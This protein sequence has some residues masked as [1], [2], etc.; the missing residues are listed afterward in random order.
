[1]NVKGK[2]VL[3]LCLKRQFW[4]T[5]VCMPTLS[6]RQRVT[7]GALHSVSGRAGTQVQAISTSPMSPALITPVLQQAMDR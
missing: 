7:L 5:G 4:P 1:M 3:L 2:Y 6:W